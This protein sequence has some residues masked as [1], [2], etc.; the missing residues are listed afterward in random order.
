VITFEF[1]L[2]WA[3]IIGTTL[4]GLHW[5]RRA[6]R[7]YRGTTSLGQTIAS[8]VLPLLLI[9]IMAAGIFT[10]W[11]PLSVD[12]LRHNGSSYQTG[13]SQSPVWI[14]L[15]SVCFYLAFIAIARTNRHK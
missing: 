14:L 8:M 4:L 2:L 7:H 3:M 11:F 12:D 9:S 13:P 5:G 10:H 6:L 1:Y 15:A